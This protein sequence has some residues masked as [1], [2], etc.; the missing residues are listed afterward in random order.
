[1]KIDKIKINV[2]YLKEKIIDFVNSKNF[3][4]NIEIVDDGETIL[5]T[6]GGTLSLL[7]KSNR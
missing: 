3:P 2:F 6:G 7:N 4:I 5:G 1:M